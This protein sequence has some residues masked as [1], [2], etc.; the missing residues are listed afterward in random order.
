MQNCHQF[1]K[2]CPSSARF[3]PCFAN[4]QSNSANFGRILLRNRPNKLTKVLL[5]STHALGW[6]NKT[7][8]CIAMQLQS[9]IFA[10]ES[11]Q[12][13][14]CKPNTADSCPD[15]H[16][17]S[18]KGSFIL[19]I[20]KISPVIWQE[21]VRTRFCTRV[22]SKYSASQNYSHHWPTSLANILQSCLSVLPFACQILACK[23]HRMKE[24]SFCD[25]YLFNKNAY[26]V[27]IAKLP[28]SLPFAYQNWHATCIE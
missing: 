13:S 16:E 24:I 15:V 14:F 7:F 5:S 22:F 4:F 10:L 28:V 23:I 19:Q 17:K 12:R 2:F 21:S 1:C 11:A 6:Q 20:C 3:W 8:L 9:T 25:P 26:S 27:I 18:E